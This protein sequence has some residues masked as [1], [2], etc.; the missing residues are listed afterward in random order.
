VERPPDIVDQMV[1]VDDALARVLAVFSPLPPVD[2]PILEADGL[3]L[4]GDVFAGVDVPPFANSAMDG[5]AVRSIDTVGA[6]GDDPVALE[7]IGSSA[8]GSAASPMVRPG[9]AVRVMTGAPIPT[10]ADAVVRFEDTDEFESSPALHQGNSIRIRHPAKP[11][12][13]VR[14]AGEDV[15][16]GSLAL[17]RGTILRPPEIGLLAALNLTT[18]Q[19]HRRPRVAI[20]STGDEI[21]GIGQELRPGQIRDTNSYLLAAL[22]KRYGAIPIS[23]GIARDTTADLSEK[24][25]AAGDFDLI[26]TSGGVSVGDYDVVKHV[27]RSEGE[28]EIWQ[29]RMK[30]GKPLAF[31]RIGTTPLLGL[32]GNPVAAAVSFEK[33]ARPVIKRMVG[34]PDLFAPVVEATLTERFDNLGRRRHFVRARVDRGP[35]AGYAVRPVGKQGA[36]NIS[37]LSRANGLM[38]VPEDV[39]LAEPGDVLPVQMI[40]W[41]TDLPV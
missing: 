25:A 9:T 11:S 3:V 29:V 5:Y 37:S 23:L 26:V 19:V 40:D 12:Q 38:V 27:L 21:A 31:G 18:V 35:T 34:R 13:N 1:S 10:H 28:I 22:A 20:L 32:P 24:L 36:G 8:A 33:F 14:T 39:E 16:R 17:S 7:L 41:F 6:T 2:I 4:A 15:R 30:P